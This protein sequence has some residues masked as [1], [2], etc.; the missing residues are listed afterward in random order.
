MPMNHV[1]RKLC[2]SEK[3]A[4]QVASV[5]PEALNGQELGESVLEIGPGFGATT[6][7]LV[8]LVPKLTAVE[9]DEA[10]TALL[11]KEFGDRATIRQGDGAALPFEDGT[12]SSVVCFTMLH[13]VPTVA[14]QDAIFAEAH[15]VLRP[16]GLFFATD[17]QLSFRF[18]LLHIGDTMNVLDASTL[19][20]RLATAGFTGVEVDHEPK[21]RVKFS[22]TKPG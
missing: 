15:R 22:A 12:F 18:R 8:D 19:P 16:G 1:H 20:G 10:S 6:R 14:R 21:R 5:L 13:H 9:I 3:W 4:S 7:V 11:H 17:S 2:S